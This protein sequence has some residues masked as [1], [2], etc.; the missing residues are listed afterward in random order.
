MF[1]KL[2]LVNS[3]DHKFYQFDFSSKKVKRL[4]LSR[5]ETGMSEMTRPDEVW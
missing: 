1:G 5:Y 4:N 3:K 2:K